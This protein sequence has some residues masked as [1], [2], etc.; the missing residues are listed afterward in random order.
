MFGIAG[1]GRNKSPK[2]KGKNRC[3]MKDFTYFHCYAEDLWE[4]YEK[5]GLLRGSFGIRIC[6]SVRLPEKLRFNE[7]A[8][9][10]GRLYQYVEKHRPALYVD[11]LQ[12]GDYIQEYP[13]DKAL[14]GVYKEMLGE[15]FLGLQMHEWLSNYRSDVSDKLGDLPAEE[16]TK[17]SIARTVRAKFPYPRLFVESMTLEELAEAGKPLTHRQFYENMT[18]IYKKRAQEY[19][20]VPC[21]S[22]YMMFPFEA[23]NGARVIM[24]EI[25]GQIPSTRLQMCYARGVCGAYGITL[26]AYYEP[27]GGEPFST[28]T[29]QKDGKN[30]WLL[31]DGGEFP[32]LPGGPN[33]GSSRSLQWRIHLYAYLSGARVMA[34]EWGGYNTF[35]DREDFNLSEYGLV[36]K[37]FLDFVDRYPDVGEKL[38]PIAAVVA[39]D[40]PAFSICINAETDRK[41]LFGYELCGEE[42]IRHQAM[43]E[44][45]AEIFCKE[46]PM[47]G[48]EGK[49]LIN[50]PVPDAVDMLNEGDGNALKKYRYLVNLTGFSDFAKKHAN[51]IAPEAVTEALHALLPCKVEGGLHYLVNRRGE[52]GYYLSVFNHS[53]VL[54]TQAEGERILPEATQTVCISLKEGRTL[55]PLE[56]SRDI[57]ERDGRYYVTVKGGD[58][59]FAAF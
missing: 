56:G 13:F 6:H 35:T 19:P 14:I 53:G 22:F 34:E 25:G 58:W 4:G 1:N 40:L 55:K 38:A 39:N 30:E 3:Y 7:L 33:G 57:T 32:F 18:A 27:W 5:N 16:W 41:R 20:L 31:E 59:F 50:S 54:R 2:R 17:E 44:A 36:K 43:Q 26:G 47:M 10:G 29:Y 48:S 46:S 28:C 23:E 42:L 12:G 11:R 15:K 49:I 9:V 8:R 52:D 45:A 21:D 37:R 24:P 51:C